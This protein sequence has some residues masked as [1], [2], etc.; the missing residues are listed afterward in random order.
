MATNTSGVDL[1]NYQGLLAAGAFT[2][3]G[4]RVD[5]LTLT[6]DY[7]PGAPHSLPAC[8][9]RRPAAADAGVY[10]GIPCEGYY[11]GSHSAKATQDLASLYAELR[12]DTRWADSN[13]T[14]FSQESGIDDSGYLFPSIDDV[15]KR[16]RA[17]ELEQA[18]Y[19]PG[20]DENATLITYRVA[21]WKSRA[22]ET[23]GCLAAVEAERVAAR[24]HG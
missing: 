20:D 13:R 9:V 4:A 1:A 7:Y 2:N 12:D 10:D 6:W 8:D 19:A 18:G 14:F 3:H 15:F 22:A 16:A 24:K 5:D 21:A 11:A 17:A 23:T